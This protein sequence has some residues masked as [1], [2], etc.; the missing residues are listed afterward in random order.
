MDHTDEKQRPSSEEK[1]PQ[2]DDHTGGVLVSKHASEG[3]TTGTGTGDKGED[4]RDGWD[5]RRERRVL[6]RMDIHL[7]PFVSLLYLL[8]FL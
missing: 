2:A 7:L 4:W 8:S 5:G 6:R 3:S 1:S